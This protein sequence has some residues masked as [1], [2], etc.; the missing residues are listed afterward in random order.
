MDPRHTIL[1]EPVR[2]GPVTAPNRFYQTPH[3]TRLGWQRPLASLALGMRR[4]GETNRADGGFHPPDIARSP[5][6]RQ[7]PQPLR[8]VGSYRQPEPRLVPGPQSGQNHPV[9]LGDVAAF[10]LVI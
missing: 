1:F 7:M 9:V 5:S 2:I 8:H 6:A 4:V 10:Q 3:A